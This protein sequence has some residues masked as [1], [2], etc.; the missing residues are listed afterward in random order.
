MA[1]K[2]ENWNHRQQDG[3]HKIERETEGEREICR[4][5]ILTGKQIPKSEDI[6]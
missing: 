3:A 2:L 5:S 6:K 1:E 4:P